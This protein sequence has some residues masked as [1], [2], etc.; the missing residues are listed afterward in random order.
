MQVGLHK[1]LVLKDR[2]GDGRVK[3]AESHMAVQIICP[4]PSAEK[5]LSVPEDLGASRSS[6]RMPDGPPQCRIARS[7]TAKRRGEFH[8]KIGWFLPR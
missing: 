7:S 6:A 2:R 8:I 5:I 4:N 1:C 3:I